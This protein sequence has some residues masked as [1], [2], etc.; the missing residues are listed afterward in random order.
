MNKQFLIKLMS[1]WKLKDMLIKLV[2]PKN[3]KH[4]QTEVM[5]IM[6]PT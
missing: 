4:E 2:I 6:I 1:L 3:L 5:E